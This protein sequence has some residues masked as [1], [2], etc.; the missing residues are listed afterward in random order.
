MIRARLAPEVGALLLKALDAARDAL[1]RRREDMAEADPP[2]MEQQQ[3]D[4]LALLAE[5][6]LHHGIDPGAPGERYQVWSTSTPPF[7]PTRPS[8][9]NPCSKTAYAFRLERLSA[10]PATRPESSCATTPTGA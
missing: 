5:T 2:T 3:A 1:Y 10:W 7:W 8:P 6:A 4:A 9:A